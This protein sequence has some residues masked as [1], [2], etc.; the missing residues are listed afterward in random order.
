LKPIGGRGE[1]WGDWIE[2]DAIAA[3]DAIRKEDR[4]AMV[5]TMFETKSQSVERRPKSLEEFSGA[6]QK[7][8]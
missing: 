4:G 5:P 1:I 2:A 3:M 7:D 6:I 8:L